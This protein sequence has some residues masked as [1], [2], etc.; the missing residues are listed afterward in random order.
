MK[1]DKCKKNE[2]NFHKVSNINGKVSEIHLCSE[3]AKSSKEFNLN[4]DFE[5]FNANSRN[6]LNNFMSDFNST[7]SYFTSPM[8]NSF[9]DFDNFLEDELFTTNKFLENKKPIKGEYESKEK[10]KENVES[11]TN[12]EKISLE[13]QKLDLQLKKAVV[14]ERYEDAIKLRDKIKELKEKIK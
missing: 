12:N 13:L 4:E 14:E 7:F 8:L 6:F 5:I 9:L 11:L 1:C 2:A 3:C 10:V